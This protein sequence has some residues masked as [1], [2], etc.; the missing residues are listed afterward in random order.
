MVILCHTREAWRTTTMYIWERTPECRLSL[1]I[2]NQPAPS[3]V[4]LQRNKETKSETAADRPDPSMSTDAFF[5]LIGLT[6]CS[7]YF[8]SEKDSDFWKVRFKSGF[9]KGGRG[10]ILR[11]KEQKIRVKIKIQR[12]TQSW[13]SGTILRLKSEWKG[14][15]KNLRITIKSQ[16]HLV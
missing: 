15:K 11:W 5:F 9:W 12:N 14:E 4:R 13:K 6:F 16:T 3:A 1:R 10:V 8:N 2:W 7:F